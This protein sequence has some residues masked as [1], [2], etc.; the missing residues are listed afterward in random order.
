MKEFAGVDDAL[1][2]WQSNCRIPFEDNNIN[3]KQK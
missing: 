3:E 2:R 1:V